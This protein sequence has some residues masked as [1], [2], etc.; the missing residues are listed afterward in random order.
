MTTR[1]ALAQ[2]SFHSNKTWNDGKQD[3]DSSVFS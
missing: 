3:S 2:P 1:A